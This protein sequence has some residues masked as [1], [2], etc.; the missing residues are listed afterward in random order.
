MLVV[1]IILLIFYYYTKSK[2]LESFNNSSNIVVVV[3]CVPKHLSYLP[4]LFDSINKQTL[5]PTKVIVTLSQT[6]DYDCKRFEIMYRQSLDSDIDLEFKCVKCKN[7][8]AENRN[9]AVTNFKG[10]DYIAYMDADDEMCPDKLKRMSELM[11]KHNADMGLHSFDN[12]DNRN[13]CK[14]GNRVILA[15]EMRKIEKEN[16]K[17]LHLASIPVHHGHSMIKPK[18]IQK[19]KQDPYFGYGEDSKFVRD[20]IQSGFNVIYTNDQL[21]HYYFNRSATYGK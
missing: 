10:I 4:G 15:P 3:P 20:V 6:N 13:K 5:H 18:V 17:T 16:N 1:F 12:G 9:R 8:S 7:N 19:I 11:K 2:I 14:K 21:S